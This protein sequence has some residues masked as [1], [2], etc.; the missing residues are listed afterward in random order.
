MKGRNLLALQEED[1]DNGEEKGHYG[2]QGNFCDQLIE[3]RDQDSQVEYEDGC[4]GE[5]GRHGVQDHTHPTD[6]Q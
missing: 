5:A 2:S 1:Q 6:L 3:L 4:F